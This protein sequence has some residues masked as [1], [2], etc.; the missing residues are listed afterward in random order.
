MQNM[1]DENYKVSCKVSRSSISAR[2]TKTQRYKHATRLGIGMNNRNAI[3]RTGFPHLVYDVH[4]MNKGES[5]T[6][7]RTQGLQ[8]INT[9]HNQLETKSKSLREYTAVETLCQS[10]CSVVCGH[11]C[12]Q[13]D[14]AN[15]SHMSAGEG[16]IEVLSKAS[17]R[18][19]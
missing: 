11:G 5:T 1:D 19:R 6:S 16:W 4:V 7:G 17:V 8:I 3:R 13:S 9:S 2:V 12:V 10:F 14:N 15:S 18:P